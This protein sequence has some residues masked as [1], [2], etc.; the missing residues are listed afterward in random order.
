MSE[1]LAYTLT[2]ESSVPRASWVDACFDNQLE[3]EKVTIAIESNEASKQI[4]PH[5]C[6]MQIKSGESVVTVNH[7]PREISRHCYF[8]LKEEREEGGLMIMCL[9]QLIDLHSLDQAVWRSLWFGD[10]K[11]G[12]MSRIVK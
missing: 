2:F 9:V 1:S 6:A 3:N 10:F 5:C 11:V 8:V 7:I 4:D 12:G